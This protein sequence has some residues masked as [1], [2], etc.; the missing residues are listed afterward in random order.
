MDAQTVD[1]APRLLVV[2]V[3]AF[4]QTKY[5]TFVSQ[6]DCLQFTWRSLLL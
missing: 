1:A 4:S 2:L 5:L 3:V 6:S